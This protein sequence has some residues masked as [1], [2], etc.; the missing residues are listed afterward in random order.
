M[1]AQGPEFRSPE[2]TETLDIGY[3]SLIQELL[4]TEADLCTSLASQLSDLSALKLI[5]LSEQGKPK[6]YGEY[7]L[8]PLTSMFIAITTHI[9]THPH[10]E[11]QTHLQIHTS[12]SQKQI[13][14]IVE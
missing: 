3:T 4:G 10:R 6:E 7:T 1:Q 8:S 9:G 11:R 13:S 12:S 2:P 5:A 14:S